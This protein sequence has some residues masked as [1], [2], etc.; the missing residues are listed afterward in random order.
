[1]RQYRLQPGRELLRIVVRPEMHEEE[2]GLF[3]DHVVVHRRDP[4]PVLAQGPQHRIHFVADSTKSPVIAA[5]PAPWA[6]S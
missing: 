2:A 4:D 3:V 5:L 1:M 6:E